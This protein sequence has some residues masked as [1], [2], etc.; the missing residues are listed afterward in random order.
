MW[1]SPG[2]EKLKLSLEKINIK[3][4]LIKYAKFPESCKL[5]PFS[6][7]FS[8]VF[9]FDGRVFNRRSIKS[10]PSFARYLVNM[11]DRVG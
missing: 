6:V 1:G 8:V 7:L 5:T 10:F 2:N 4:P 9:R 11:S 3:N